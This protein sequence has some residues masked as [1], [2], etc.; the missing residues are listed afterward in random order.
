MTIPKLRLISIVTL[1][2][3][4]HICLASDSP[5]LADATPTS[6]EYVSLSIDNIVVDTD[7]LMQVTNQLSNSIDSLSSSIERLS[8][9]GSTF[10]EKDRLALI[11]AATSV[12][13]ASQSLSQLS[14]QIPI[15]IRQL[16]HELPETLENT[17]PQIEAISKSIQSASQAAIN[18]NESFPETLAN[19]KLAMSEITA[20]VMQKVTLYIGVIL[21]M[22]ALVL[23]VLMYIVYRTSIRPIANGLNELRAVPGQLS[24]MSAYMHD[25][26]E[27]L[28]SLEQLQK[29]RR[30]REKIRRL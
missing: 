22:F 21:I 23:A 12:S 5:I 25:T 20:D 17:Q 19:G 15:A 27:N 16:T 1:Y 6:S 3:T 24:K 2:L 4:S 8:L 9:N 28:L 14:A 13:Q 30:R 7:G 11:S 26:S 10:N 29:S 18:I